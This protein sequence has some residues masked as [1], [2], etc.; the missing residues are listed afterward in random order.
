MTYRELDRDDDAVRALVDGLKVAVAPMDIAAAYYR[1][2]FLLWQAG[3]PALGL[4]CYVQVPRDTYF[5]G[6]TQVEMADLMRDA[7]ITHA[8]S[9][10][11]ARGSLRSSGI[12]VAPVPAAVEEAAQAAIGL[13][14]AGF[15]DAAGALVHFLSSTDVAP[16]CRDV[17]VA[18]VPAAVEEAAQA[19]IGLVDAGFF[20]AAGALVHFLSSTDVAP[21]CRDV[22][23][24]VLRSLV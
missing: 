21:N 20:D 17:P 7:H 16:N 2:G 22:L 23:P 8:P 18:P 15:F 24:A 5:Y 3:N 4:A 19:A 10:S 9:I 14:D 6:E 1:L 13:V 11:E 12:P